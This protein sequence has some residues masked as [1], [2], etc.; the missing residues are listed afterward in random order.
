M[1]TNI[2]LGREKKRKLTIKQYIMYFI[3]RSDAR[4]Q[5]SRMC[6]HEIIINWSNKADTATGH[7]KYE[8]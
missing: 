2:T 4:V 5:G 1:L 3:L 6:R 8:S 7:Q